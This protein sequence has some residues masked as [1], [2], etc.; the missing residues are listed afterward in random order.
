M[1]LNRWDPLRDL[2]TIQEKL[3]RVLASSAGE[4]PR[5]RKARWC[6]DV[7]MLETPE[8]YIFR[9]ELAG[10]GKENISIEV[11]GRRLTIAGERFPES[12]PRAAAYHSI[13]RVHGYFERSFNLPERVDL[14]DAEATYVDGVLE[15]SLPK[16]LNERERTITVVCLS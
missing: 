4:A 1:S 14:E 5:K 10:V 9:A 3:H 8:A 6:P 11:H 13:E 12:E 15:V 2:L 16:A 7:D